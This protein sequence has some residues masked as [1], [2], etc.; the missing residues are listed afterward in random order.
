MVVSATNC[1][2]CETLGRQLADAK[3]RDVLSP[4]AYLVKVDA[5]DLHGSVAAR[6]KVGT[7]TLESPGFPTTWVWTVTE[8]GLQFSAVAIGPLDEMRPDVDVEAL[9]HGRSTWVPEAAGISLQVCSGGLCL[10]LNQGNDFQ[11]DFA[12]A[13]AEG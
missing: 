10:P 3:V 8:A 12:L 11:A 9:M 1:S 5:G 13:L 2:G 6:I 4:D 7:W